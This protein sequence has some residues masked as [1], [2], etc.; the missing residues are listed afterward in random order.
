MCCGTSKFAGAW[1]H[2]AW[3]CTQRRLAPWRRFA[4]NMCDSVYLY[5]VKISSCLPGLFPSYFV[6]PLFF[7]RR[8]LPNFLVYEINGGIICFYNSVHHSLYVFMQSTDRSTFTALRSC[9]VT[10]WMFSSL[11]VRK[12]FEVMSRWSTNLAVQLCR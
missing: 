12:R 4:L 9:Q 1:H 10:Y 5:V 3:G 8:M 7:T 2:H 6:S 11:Y